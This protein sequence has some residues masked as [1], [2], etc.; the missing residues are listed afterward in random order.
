MHPRLCG[1]PIHHPLRT[2]EDNTDQ[3]EMLGR[4]YGNCTSASGTLAAPQQLIGYA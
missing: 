4:D 1:Y 2:A 3:I